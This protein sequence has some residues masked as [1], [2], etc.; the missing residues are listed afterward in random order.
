MNDFNAEMPKVLKE[1]T[2]CF[3]VN[4]YIVSKNL[5]EDMC[6]L[7]KNYSHSLKF[8]DYNR[9]KFSQTDASTR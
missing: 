4:D 9:K 8:P 3:K 7:P 2:I 6:D 5:K 1:P